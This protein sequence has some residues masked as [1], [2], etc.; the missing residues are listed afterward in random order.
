MQYTPITEVTIRSLDALSTLASKDKKA[1]TQIGWIAVLFAD[2][3]TEDFS[4]EVKLRGKYEIAE[5]SM[6]VGFRGRDY[7]LLR[8]VYSNNGRASMKISI[9]GVYESEIKREGAIR[10]VD[11]VR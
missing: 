4:C 3:K 1:S 9:P 11:G 5:F 10:L 8:F 7:G 2:I 6:V